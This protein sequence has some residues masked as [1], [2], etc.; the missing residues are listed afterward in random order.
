VKSGAENTLRVSTLPEV[1]APFRADY[2]LESLIRESLGRRGL[3][4]ASIDDT[5]GRVAEAALVSFRAAYEREPE[6]GEDPTARL[7]A[8]ER[9]RIV[10][11]STAFEQAG[12]LYVPLNGGVVGIRQ[13]VLGEWHRRGENPL[14]RATEATL[15]YLS[16]SVDRSFRAGGGLDVD[17]DV[18]VVRSMVDPT[19]RDANGLA[20]SKRALLLLTAVS[21]YVGEKG[22]AEQ[23]FSPVLSTLT[24][25]SHTLA[26]A[27]V[28]EQFARL[29]LVLRESQVFEYPAQRTA[30]LKQAGARY[31]HDCLTRIV[32]ANLPPPYTRAQRNLQSML[33]SERFRARQRD[34]GMVALRLSKVASLLD[35]L[36]YTHGSLRQRLECLAENV[37]VVVLDHMAG[38]VEPSTSEIAELNTAGAT[39]LKPVII[40]PA[41]VLT[42]RYV[43]LITEQILGTTTLVGV[44]GG[45]LGDR[46]R[47]HR[48]RLGATQSHLA[49]LAGISRKELSRVERG[50]SMPARRTLDRLEQALQQM[51]LATEDGTFRSRSGSKWDMKLTDKVQMGHETHGLGL[52]CTA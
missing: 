37:S 51:E 52:E 50:R 42:R 14:G 24:W 36:G 27:A 20:K 6:P 10:G 5:S 35:D 28:S 2:H 13:D 34:G 39:E 15:R 40:F 45:H 26:R 31:F 7:T 21:L 30:F 11:R 48:R 12:S 8:S 3:F 47:K 49:D 9:Q 46:L 23:Q 19:G 43:Q 25:R 17:I 44:H 16:S 32:V 1:L 29:H 4:P 38:T 18:D 41:D 22:S 33:L